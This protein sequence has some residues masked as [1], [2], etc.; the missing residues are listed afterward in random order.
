MAI[1]GEISYKLTV[2]TKELKKGLEDGSK[3]VEKSAKDTKGKLANLA[4]GAAS[5]A[6][7]VAKVVGGAIAAG[8]AAAAAGIT[9]I[10]TSATKSY[11]DF[12]Q[13]AGGVEKIFKDSADTVKQYAD[14]AFADAGLSAN[15]YMEQVTGFSQSLINS[16][17]GDT[18]RAAEI[19]NKAIIDMS[20]NANT[21]GTDIASI[22][23]AYQGFAKQ[24][25]NMLDNLKLGYG[26]TKT[27]MERLLADAEK[28]SGI[29][30]DIDSFAD[31]AE[32]I[33]V[34]QQEAAIAGT[35]Q[36]E[37]AKTL[38]GSLGATKAAWANLITELGKPGGDIGAKMD[39]FIKSAKDFEGNL[40]P[41]FKRAIR[42]AVDLI[43]SLAPQIIAEIPSLINELI[44]AALEAAEKLI[45]AIVE[46]FPQLVQ[47][48][49]NVTPHIV[50]AVV[51]ITETLVANLPIFVQTL[52]ELVLAVA[53]A[54]IAELPRILKAIV[55]AV[56]SIIQ[57]LTAPE[58]L[59]AI[60]EA[61]VM[62]LEALVDSIPQILDALA[63]ALPDI[64][65]S[66][67]AFLV[68][69]KTLALII[70]AGVTLFMALVQAIPQILDALFQAF[71]N[72]FN[73][74]W[75]KL[76]TV[77]T[78]FAGRF[79]D[80]MG[81]VF[82]RAVNGVIGF[83]EKFIN[84]P[85]QAINN[86]IDAINV[87]PGVNI[88]KL[89]RISIP[90]MET[91]GIVPSTAGGRLILAGEGGQDEWIVPES[92]MAS[93]IEQLNQRGVGEGV[94]INIQGVFATSESEQRRVAE[95]IYEK[96]QQLNRSKMGAYL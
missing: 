24:Q 76:Q 34:I 28:F 55:K 61:G 78:D 67:V 83:L 88:G 36:N 11:G 2:D 94:T 74:L 21:F 45:A 53:R 46:A 30:Y 59:S 31:V 7:S 15:D 89:P 92:K 47:S 42:G 33:H 73:N 19:A 27:E 93:M 57:I 95:Q 68:D 79:G 29:H 87:I 80:A 64:I 65:S 77:F 41:I 84:G 6:A 60:L 52:L 35:T 66:I 10:A 37:A 4:K 63:V 86:G 49:A 18:A 71:G 44:P 72:L 8:T 3:A 14:R 81:G 75:N 17:N 39:D 12:E 48:L 54:I 40:L 38:T 85:I 26:G 70:R 32:A 69:P 16:L 1:A 90:R 23:N 25:Y 5:T 91:G 82:K 20:D 56:M 58:N 22:Q 62:L 43:A 13:L 9:A 50:K 96:L 51:G